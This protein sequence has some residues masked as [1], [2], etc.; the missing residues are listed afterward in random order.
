M[1]GLDRGLLR[2]ARSGQVD[3]RLVGLRLGSVICLDEVR[4]ALL[5]A[6][7]AL[8]EL[9]VQV[10]R[11]EQHERRQLDGPGGR[12][13]R[14]RVAG[15]DEQRQATAMVE[16]RMG[17]HD[18]VE[19]RRIEPERDPVPD[20]LVGAALEHPTIDQD[21]RSIGGDEEL[22]AG[23]GGGPTEEVDLHAAHGDRPR[24]AADLAA[25]GRRV[26]RSLRYE[27]EGVDWRPRRTAATG[28][29]SSSGRD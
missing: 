17:Q 3:R 25:R 8:G 12:V 26:A 5:P 21:L 6:R 7:L 20:R 24:R 15:L 23:D 10:S 19:L 28:S 14:A 27:D 1:L 11:V 16:V 9:L 2:T 18:R 29:R 13:D 22:R 4:V